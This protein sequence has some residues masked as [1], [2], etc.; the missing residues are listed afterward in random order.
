MVQGYHVTS[1]LIQSGKKVKH[2]GMVF[3]LEV[4]MAQAQLDEHKKQHNFFFDMDGP[5]PVRIWR[6]G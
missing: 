5:L 6:K 3:I 1:S 4:I 2:Y